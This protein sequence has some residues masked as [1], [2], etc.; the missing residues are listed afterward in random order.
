MWCVGVNV[1][2]GRTEIMAVIETPDNPPTCVCDGE[3]W[4]T[5]AAHGKLVNPRR[6][7]RRGGESLVKVERSETNRRQL[8]EVRVLPGT[9]KNNAS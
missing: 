2:Q 3:L 7:G 5:R 9:Q 1:S 8:V 6:L 4:Y